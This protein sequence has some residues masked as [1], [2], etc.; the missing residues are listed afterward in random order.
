MDLHG[1]NGLDEWD[2]LDGLDRRLV[3]ALQL[4]GRAA[5]TRVGEV[6]GVSHQTVARRYRSLRAAGVLRVRGLPHARRLG[7]TEWSLRLRCRPAAAAEVARALARRADTGWVA[8]TAT[9]GEVLCTL[10]TADPATRDGLLLR[11]LP[12]TADV[13]EVSASCL[14][15][16]H[17]GDA[18]GRGGRLAALDPGQAAAL[19]RPAPGGGAGAEP[20]RPDATDPPLFAALAADGRAS[21]RELAA[22]LGR[23]ETWARERIDRLRRHG[24][25]YFEADVDAA[26]LGHHS[27][28]ALWLTTPPAHTAA[29]ARALTTHSPVVF[30]A[31]VTGR[32]NLVAAVV[33]RDAEALHAYLDGPL[34]ELAAVTHVESVPVLHIVKRR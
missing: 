18:A 1:P 26:R 12:R 25:L 5:F 3:H 13:R 8:L 16:T 2:G 28:T 17:V 9:A 34:R 4:D 6:L 19:R 15:R 22:R 30:A 23:S 21:A 11:T 27:T 32:S 20:H 14:L 10:R 7:H 29:V 31:T 24:T 33:T